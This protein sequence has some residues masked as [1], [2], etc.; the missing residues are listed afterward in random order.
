MSGE[1]LETPL[2]NV[3]R[4]QH[5]LLLAGMNAIATPQLAAA[6][7]N[8]GG[9]GVIGGVGYTP[10]QLRTLIEEVKSLLNDKTCFGVDLLLPKVGDGARATNYDYT[11]GAL[12]ELIDII[13][14]SG[15][16]LF[17]CAVGVP[18][19]WAVDKLHAAGVACGNMVGH[20]KHVPKALET[21]AD[22][23]IAQGYEAGGHTGDV[24]TMV[25]IPQCLDQLKGRVS[26]FTGGPV[27]LVAAGGIADGRSMAAALNL[28]AEAV[29]VG[30]RF[31]ACSEAGGSKYLRE[32]VLKAGP[33]DTARSL[34][35]S[36][37]PLRSLRNDYAKSWESPE[38]QFEIARITSEGK[39]PFYMDMEAAEK[40]GREWSV[41]K[42]FINPCGQC[43]GSI[44]SIL[45]A[46]DIVDMMVSG[47]IESFR[48]K[49]AW[50]KPASKL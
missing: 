6:V 18:P 38:K 35:W 23:I 37:R 20:P 30:T 24:A 11:G 3:L 36:G 19:K 17:V 21:G 8:A 15:A 2:T 28:G 4:I 43:V 46:K 49:T 16:K 33:T 47:C 26:A 32:E 31:I 29:W 13:A 42:N 22:I 10:D 34:I 50:I 5:P 25:L 1:T 12:P 7:S 39:L 27:H 14:A 45:T 40:E 9:L 41:V 48:S 44:N